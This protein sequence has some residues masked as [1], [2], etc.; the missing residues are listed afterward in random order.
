MA[1]IG[2]E[3][4]VDLAPVIQA[5]QA[6][7]DNSA[8]LA[9]GQV[10][11][12]SLR[13]ARTLCEAGLATTRQAIEAKTTTPGHPWNGKRIVWAPLRVRGVRREGGLIMQ[14]LQDYEVTS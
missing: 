9:L 5:A 13:K 10:F 7:L 2:Y 8:P 3:I 14:A 6:A 11:I 1:T 12:A 4:P